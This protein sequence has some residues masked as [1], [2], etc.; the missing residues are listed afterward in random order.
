VG[1]PRQ[2]ATAIP[3]IIG[4]ATI[5]HHAAQEEGAPVRDRSEAADLPAVLAR[6]KDLRRGIIRAMHYEGAP[7]KRVKYFWANPSGTP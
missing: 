1:V 6:E 7:I 5:L 4:N 3:P 2:D